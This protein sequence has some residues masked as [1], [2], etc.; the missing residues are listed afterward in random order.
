MLD[1]YSRLLESQF[2]KATDDELHCFNCFHSSLVDG[3]NIKLKIDRG[4][5]DQTQLVSS[6]I[7]FY[8]R[9]CQG[10]GPEVIF[11]QGKA[12][13]GTD[14][15]IWFHQ[16]LYLQER[17]LEDLCLQVHRVDVLQRVR[18]RHQSLSPAHV[19]IDWIL[20][21]VSVIKDGPNIECLVD[22]F[23]VLYD[24]VVLCNFKLGPFV[25]TGLIVVN[26]DF[27]ESSADGTVRLTEIQMELRF[28]VNNGLRGWVKLS[29]ELIRLSINEC[30]LFLA[31]D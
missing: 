22:W 25:H 6:W 27:L 17:L 26:Y 9:F 13:N 28:Q 20:C 31:A 19:D 15:H 1:P 14:R 7:Q 8:L 2:F 4:A 12:L 29:D 3:L 10:N 24:E 5:S 16:E 21:I 18:A 23:A 11:H 30:Y